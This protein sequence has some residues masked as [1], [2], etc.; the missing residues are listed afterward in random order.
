MRERGLGLGEAGGRWAEWATGLL[1]EIRRHPHPLT[2]QSRRS[3]PLPPPLHA[4]ACSRRGARTSAPCCTRRCSSARARSRRSGEGRWWRRSLR[5]RR[6]AEQRRRARLLVGKHASLAT[7]A[8]CVPSL[9]CL[10]R[11]CPY[12]AAVPRGRLQPRWP[13]LRCCRWLLQGGRGPRLPSP[14][15]ERWCAAGAQ[16]RGCSRWLRPHLRCLGCVAEYKPA[17]LSRF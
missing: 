2:H 10:S 11:C 7:R 13:L 8:L 12:V 4:S 3:P 5:R 16:S 9:P 1:Q 17:P 14:V 6:R 15:Q